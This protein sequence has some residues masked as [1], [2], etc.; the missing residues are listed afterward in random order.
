MASTMAAN[1]TGVHNVSDGDAWN[2]RQ[3]LTASLQVR[4]NRSNMSSSGMNNDR[5]RGSHNNSVGK[6]FVAG[7]PNWNNIWGDSNLGNGFG[8][9][10]YRLVMNL[11]LRG[12]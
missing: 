2:V 3:A 5:A 11:S 4:S 12:G 7:K 8:D 1:A 9:G 10:M 6:S